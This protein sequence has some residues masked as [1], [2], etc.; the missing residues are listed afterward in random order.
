MTARPAM[1]AKP[2]LDLRVLVAAE[3]AE[4][5][6]SLELAVGWTFIRLD[7]EIGRLGCCRR[8]SVR[9]LV[10]VE[11]H[12]EE[13]AL[14]A[15]ERELDRALASRISGPRRTGPSPAPTALIASASATAT[16]V[17][18]ATAAA[19]RR[20]PCGS[21]P[22]S[23]PP[24]LLRP[25]AR[26]GVIA[27]AMN[28]NTESGLSLRFRRRALRSLVAGL[29]PAAA[30]IARA[31]SAPRRSRYGVVTQG[32]PQDVRDFEFGRMGQGDV[33]SVRFI[34]LWPLIQATPG[35]CGPGRTT[36]FWATRIPS[37]PRTT[38]T[39]P[40]STAWSA[41]R[42]RAG[43]PRCRSSSALPTGPTATTAS[44][45][46]WRAASRRSRPRRTGSPG[47]LSPRRGAALRARTARSGRREA[48]TRLSTRARRRCRSRLAGL[49]R[50]QLARVL[51]AQAVPG[52]LRRPARPLCRRHSRRGPR[53]ADHPRR[54]V[55]HPGRRARAGSSCRASWTASTTCRASRRTSTPSR[56]TRTRR[57]SRG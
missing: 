27:A 14:L 29:L 7:A 56:C 31:G 45:L 32:Y 39:G 49:E 47:R 11:V 54:A 28:S 53:S 57:G 8:D 25:T 20:S 26:P 3:V 5:G 23:F 13:V 34:L 42:R 37:R 46:T 1:R 36:P 48:T 41:R 15:H 33:S 22:S 4:I 35:P 2:S 40:R 9:E 44:R 21:R 17:P 50:A 16:A 30:A 24:L 52:R 51:L 19:A 18:L 43:R 38:A 12:D 55:R 10:G 6:V